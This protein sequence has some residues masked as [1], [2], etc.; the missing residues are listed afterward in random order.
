MG[1]IQ[2]QSS[3]R[4]MNDELLQSYEVTKRSWNI[5]YVPR[6]YY[7]QG[8]YLCLAK[9]FTTILLYKWENAL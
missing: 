7:N 8:K 6:K 1:R 9:S 4:N 5:Y 3:I 2:Y